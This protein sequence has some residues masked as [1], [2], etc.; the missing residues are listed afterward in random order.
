MEG[1]VALATALIPVLGYDR[2]VAVAAEAQ[3]DGTAVRD[4]VVR[5]GWLA[6]EDLDRLL[7]P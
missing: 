5:N 4:I 7:R 1:S 3:R 2:S 6:R